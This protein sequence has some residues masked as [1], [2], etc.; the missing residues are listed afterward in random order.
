M[1]VII[2]CLIHL[3]LQGL[4]LWFIHRTANLATPSGAKRR[5]AVLLLLIRFAALIKGLFSLQPSNLRIGLA[6]LPL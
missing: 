3:N 1:F 6:H 2:T 4:G 5:L